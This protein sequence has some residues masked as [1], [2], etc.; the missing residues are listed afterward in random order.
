MKLRKDL[1]KGVNRMRNLFHEIVKT[2]SFSDWGITSFL[3]GVYLKRFK[4]LSY[5]EEKTIKP[6]NKEQ[7]IKVHSTCFILYF[8]ILISLFITL[9]FTSV[10][11]IYAYFI[12]V[13]LLL[14]VFAYRIIKEIQLYR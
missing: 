3:Y 7:Y 13:L 9:N 11:N 8:I 12:H 10:Q 2:I 6:E 5:V 1:Y 4:K 14:I